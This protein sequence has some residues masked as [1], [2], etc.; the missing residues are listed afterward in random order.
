MTNLTFEALGIDFRTVFPSVIYSGTWSQDGARTSLLLYRPTLDAFVKNVPKVR[1]VLI[2][3]EST[4]PARVAEWTTSASDKKELQSQIRDLLELY[5][6]E[7]GMTFS[8]TPL[9]EVRTEKALK[10]ALSPLL[11][12][13][14]P[15][16]SNKESSHSTSK[17]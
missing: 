11:P 6:R 7:F 1:G 8:R 13:P 9:E 2:F 12:L 14:K 5:A 10:A 15:A 16:S 3:E 17:Q 4:S